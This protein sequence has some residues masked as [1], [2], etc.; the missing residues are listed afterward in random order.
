[1]IEALKQKVLNN[2]KISHRE[3]VELSK[4]TNKQALY[5][6]ANEIRRHFCK[7]TLE[8]CSITNA[9][10][11]KCSENCKWCSQSA[12]YQT[13]IKEYD[14]VE[15]NQAVAE[16]YNSYQ[17]GVSRHSLVTSGRKV[18]DKTLD[19]LILIYN[20]ISARCP[21]GLC[22]SLGLVNEQQIIRLK[23]EA[24]IQNYHCNLETAP[25]FFSK[26]VSTHTIEEK[27]TTIKLAQKHGINVCSGGIIG[28]G[29]NMEQ[30][31]ELALLLRELNIRSIPL[32]IL[33]PIA[34]TPLQNTSPLSEE[35]LLTSIAIF[36]FINPK[37]RL[38]F[39]GGRMQIKTFQHKALKAGINA[40]ITGD[41]LTSTGSNIQQDIKD[42]TH[43]GFTIN[44]SKKTGTIKL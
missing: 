35:E 23:E 26:L 37:A 27:I 43:A 31:I 36:R 14:I 3:A 41:Y 39:A 4:G 18:S 9:K 8:L 25:S 24:H 44:N 28:M 12:H 1:M 40:A 5:D 7:D 6:A 2:K 42:F 20:E 21:I 34:G 15:R 22:A 33:Q 38:R 19:R 13:H 11:G 32:N 10:S 30:R 29:E 17:Q 16:A